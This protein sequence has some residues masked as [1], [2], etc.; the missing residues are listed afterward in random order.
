[1]VRQTVWRRL[2]GVTGR[3]LALQPGHE[4]ASAEVV[5]LEVP[6]AWLEAKDRGTVEDYYD[7]A[8]SYPGIGPG[9]TGAQQPGGAGA[10]LLGV[11]AAATGTLEAYRRYLEIYPDGTFAGLAELRVSQAE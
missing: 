1:M 10:V 11:G 3:F 8:V 9:G 7:F 4:E 2:W 5:G 6:V